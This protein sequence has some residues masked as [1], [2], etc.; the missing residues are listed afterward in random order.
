[1]INLHKDT[2]KGRNDNFE[3]FPDGRNKFKKGHKIGRIKKRGYILFDL[4]RQ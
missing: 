4:K 1:M 3:R 2:E